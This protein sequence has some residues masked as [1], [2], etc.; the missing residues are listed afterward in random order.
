MGIRNAKARISGTFLFEAWGCVLCNGI[1]LLCQKVTNIDA[2]WAEMI[3]GY[4]MYPLRKWCNHYIK[5]CEKVKS[6]MVFDGKYELLRRNY[7][8]LVM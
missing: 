6:Y 4:K 8:K 1:D 2:K 3:K 7:G 5:L